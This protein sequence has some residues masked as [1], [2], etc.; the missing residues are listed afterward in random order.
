MKKGIKQKGK[1]YSFSCTDDNLMGEFNR[2]ISKDVNLMGNFSQAIQSAIR[3]KINSYTQNLDDEVNQALKQMDQFEKS[4][5][6]QEGYCIWDSPRRLWLEPQYLVCRN[7][8]CENPQCFTY[9]E[10]A[11]PLDQLLQLND[12]AKS[13]QIEK[14]NE[15][16]KREIQKFITT[17]KDKWEL[18]VSTGNSPLLHSKD[19]N[20]L[21]A[22]KDHLKQMYHDLIHDFLTCLDDGCLDQ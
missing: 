13:H 17:A 9:L 12:L 14:D 3:L 5:F 10:I 16:E 21:N 8:K 19:I 11:S 2:L 18:V 6:T 22:Q 7:I 4:S 15:K 1:I 20:E